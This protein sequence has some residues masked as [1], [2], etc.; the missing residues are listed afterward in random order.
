M[1]PR[2][3]F[4]TAAGVLGAFAQLELTLYDT[5]NQTESPLDLSQTL[6]VGPAAVCQTLTPRIRIHNISGSPVEIETLE[7][8]P[9]GAWRKD[10][11]DPLPGS[12][13][14]ISSASFRDVWIDFA[15]PSVGTFPATLTVNN[16]Q[17]S[18]TGEG[19][20]APEV[21]DIGGKNYCPGD[22]IYVGR[23]QVGSTVQTVLKV[24]NPTQ[25][26]VPALVS[27]KDFGPDTPSTVEPGDTQQVM[28]TFTPS[29]PNAEMG[30]LTVNGMAY[31]LAGDGFVG[32]LLQPSLQFSANAGLSSNQAQVSIPLA[33]AATATAAGQL[34]LSFQPSGTLPD[35][36]AI[37]LTATGSR[38]T[39]VLVNPGDTAVHFQA[40]NPDHCTFQT[41]TTAGTIAF[42]LT[43]GGVTSIASTTIPGALVALDLATAVAQ[44]GTVI[45]SLAGFDNTHAASRLAFT[46]Y[47]TAGQTIAPGL[48]QSDVSGPFSSYYAAHPEA[49]GAFSLQ[50]TFPVSGDISKVG[51]VD[52]QFTN[53]AGTAMTSRLPVH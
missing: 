43:I 15:P 32:P 10:S 9:L 53:P 34:T 6:D 47:D 8:A 11:R 16:L 31:T 40:G 5:T 19:V 45:V 20:A 4:L 35:D 41:G 51:G 38:T 30:M 42:T 21:S 39:S 50:A 12:S 13:F 3:L 23:T 25:A 18:L 52:V 14:V 22:Q 44:N 37:L 36:P 26:P 17:L 49:G 7:V 33:A 27:G 1:I 48:I 2:L 29:I 46:F 28:I 24:T